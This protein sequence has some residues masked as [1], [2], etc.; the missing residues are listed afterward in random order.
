VRI[1]TRPPARPLDRSGS[2]RASA[3]REHRRRLALLAAAVLTA[4]ACVTAVSTPA[5]AATVDARLTSASQAARPETSSAT[6]TDAPTTQPFPVPASAPGPASS[7]AQ[8]E[9]I[10]GWNSHGPWLD[11]SYALQKVIIA[12]SSTVTTTQICRVGGPEAW[13]LC[14]AGAVFFGGVFELLKAHRICP[15]GQS[16]RVY[17]STHPSY[18][19]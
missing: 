16:F 8:S 5:E 19:H 4:A 13:E 1:T 3:R 15:E 11:I 2:P 12:V 6:A 17:Y 18:C 9:R 10:F 7:V 14:A